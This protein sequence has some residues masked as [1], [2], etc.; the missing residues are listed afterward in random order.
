MDEPCLRTLDTDGQQRR[1]LIDNAM[2]SVIDWMIV[3]VDGKRRTATARIAPAE[4]SR[5]AKNERLFRQHRGT[6]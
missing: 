2:V 3:S 1:A 4:P 6:P 5:L